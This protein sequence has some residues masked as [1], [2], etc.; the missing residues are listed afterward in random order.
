[1]AISPSAVYLLFDHPSSTFSASYSCSSQTCGSQKLLSWVGRDSC[2]FNV[3]CLNLTSNI[4]QEYGVTV[5]VEDQYQQ[6]ICHNNQLIKLHLTN[7]SEISVEMWWTKGKAFSAKC[8]G[9]CSGTSDLPNLD[10]I[11]GKDLTDDR[12]KTQLDY[13]SKRVSS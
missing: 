12:I 2:S 9:W 6:Q 8:F 3:A 7:G 1:M 11:Q 10:N 4:C 13:V 5:E